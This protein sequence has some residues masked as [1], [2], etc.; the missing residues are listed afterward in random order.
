MQSC[1]MGVAPF[2]KEY[3]VPPENTNWMAYAKN[4]MHIVHTDVLVED[5]LSKP[6]N[7]AI[8]FFLYR[9]ANMVWMTV[10]M[11]RDLLARSKAVLEIPAFT[12]VCPVVGIDDDDFDGR[13]C[14]LEGVV[15][16]GFGFAKHQASQPAAPPLLDVRRTFCC[17]E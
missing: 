1:D 12:P 3:M 7:M 13:F 8:F 14:F 2:S 15:V 16:R 10:A 11:D 9:L 4:S 5:R 17:L 6:P